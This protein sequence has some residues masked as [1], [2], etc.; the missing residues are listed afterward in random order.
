MRNKTNPKDFDILTLFLSVKKTF[1]RSIKMQRE[2]TNTVFTSNTITHDSAALY[3]ELK[4]IC[5]LFFLPYLY[6]SL[7]HM[8]T[9]TLYAVQVAVMSDMW[10]FWMNYVV[11]ILSLAT[12][13]KGMLLHH[14]CDHSVQMIQK[15]INNRSWFLFFYFIVQPWPFCC[16]WTSRLYF[17]WHLNK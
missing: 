1:L 13:S 14:E 5:S 7:S 10:H 15:K 11:Y 2:W 16:P 4:C 6:I 3:T 17:R 12:F 9:S 8:F